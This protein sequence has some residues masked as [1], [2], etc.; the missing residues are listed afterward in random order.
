MSNDMV[1]FGGIGA[2]FCM[3]S[4]IAGI[5]AVAM[6]WL[7]PIDYA[8]AGTHIDFGTS[9]GYA[10][11]VALLSIGSFGLWKQ[12]KTP[13]NQNVGIFGILVVIAGIITGVILWR[14][15]G[16]VSGVS[17]MFSG[18]SPID[19]MGIAGIV[20][21]EINGLF[22]VL[23]GYSLYKIKEKTGVEKLARGAG[24]LTIVAGIIFMA[25]VPYGYLGGQAPILLSTIL[26]A[27][28]LFKAR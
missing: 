25:M 12:Y 21:L 27:Y 8:F 18:A 24:F 5:V 14:N 13:L 11:G 1:K 17:L 7:S 20:W 26:T 23:F 2:I 15:G 4:A 6:L 19:I 9:I 16:V 3:L 22:F 10:V 28:V